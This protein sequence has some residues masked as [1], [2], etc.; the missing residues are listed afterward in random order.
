MTNVDNGDGSGRGHDVLVLCYHAI[1]DR[2]DS[3]LAVT[4]DGIEAQ[5]EMLRQRGYV[6]ATFS[7]AMAGLGDAPVVAI[8]FDDAYLSVLERALPVLDRFGYPATVFVP[9]AF[10][11]RRTV[12]SWPGID[13][14]LGG[15]HEDEL[16]SMSWDDLARLQEA[17]WEIGSHTVDHPRLTQL[18]DGELVSQL[19]DSRAA[20]ELHLGS[21]CTSIAFPYGDV[22]DRVVRATAEAGYRYG[23]GLPGD[24]WADENPLSWPRVGIYPRDGK[25]TFARKISPFYRRL[26]GSKHWPRAIAVWRALRR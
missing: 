22:D 17:G 10:A 8:T 24:E 2:W 19:V 1:S 3:S 4:T 13:H 16:R 15:A 5:L 26:R 12:M 20:C 6:G 21:S 18:D 7:Q 9:T 25:R 14:W 23:A 11:E